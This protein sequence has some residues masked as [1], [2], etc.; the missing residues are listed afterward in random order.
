MRSKKLIL[1]L[2]LPLISII[3]GC[4]DEIIVEPEFPP[5]KWD[6]GVYIINQGKFGDGTG[7]I[8]YYGNGEL[9]K[10][11]FQTE[12]EGMVLGNIVQSM[13]TTFGGNHY[14]AINNGQRIEVSDSSNKSITSIEGL[15][16]VRYMISTNFDSRVYATSWGADGVSG[17]LYEIDPEMN[18]VIDQ[19]E[20]GGGLENMALQDLKLYIAKSGGFGT[21]SLVLRFDIR[22]KRVDEEYV[23][24]DNPVGV[25][26]DAN[27][28]IWVLCT[29]AFDFSNPENSTAGGIYKISNGEVSKELEV[30]NGSANLTIN[31]DGDTLYY[32][33]G[34]GIKVVDI[35]NPSSNLFAE[36]SFYG[37]GYFKRE[38]QIY[39]ADAKDFT[40]NGEVIIFDQNGN[41]VERIEA[42]IIPGEFYFKE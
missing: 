2:I 35:N 36:G 21:D 19:Y 37:L 20:L 3:F 41:E 31:G 30:A 42:G 25:T 27:G 22:D 34:D 9:C 24:G 12:N 18:E 13:T 40:S 29:G 7:T 14:Y 10:K 26:E 4:G 28:N 32:R 1:F 8:D 5:T 38:N 17:V 11:L 39:A 33:D 6:H 15:P 23:V 16:Q